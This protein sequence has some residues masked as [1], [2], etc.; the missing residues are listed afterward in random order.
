MGKAG[1]VA[2]GEVMQAGAR[3]S[4]RAR[5][6]C[7]SSAGAQRQLRA[8]LHDDCEAIVLCVRVTLNSREHLVAAHRHSRQDKVL[9]R[10]LTYETKRNDTTRR[11]LASHYM[12]RAGQP[13]DYVE[14]TGLLACATA[15]AQ[16]LAG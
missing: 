11:Q 15:Q 2:G 12:L 14:S 16:A 1:L 7:E 6:R 4:G 10:S 3:A 8:N 13:G 5:Q 9:H